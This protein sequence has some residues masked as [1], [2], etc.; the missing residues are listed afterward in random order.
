[1]T[2]D[3]HIAKLKSI[4]ADLEAAHDAMAADGY[5]DSYEFLDKVGAEPDDTLKAAISSLDEFIYDNSQE[6]E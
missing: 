5:I 3:E 2:H 4:L 6:D 1:M